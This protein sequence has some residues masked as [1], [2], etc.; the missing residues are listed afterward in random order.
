MNVLYAMEKPFKSKGHA[1]DGKEMTGG[2][3]HTDSLHQQRT[4]KKKLLNPKRKTF[5]AVFPLYFP[6][7]LLGK[8]VKKKK[9]NCNIL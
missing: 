4:A 6:L 8:L 5:Q 7:R 1:G 3:E 9:F 2:M